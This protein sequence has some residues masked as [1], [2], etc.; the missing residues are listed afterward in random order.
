VRL[1]EV[2][3]RTLENKPDLRYQKASELKTELESITGIFE[4]LP[5]NVQQAF[6]YEYRSKAHLFGLPLVH[7]AMGVDLRTGKK[8]V[9]KGVIAIGDIAK[10]IF[11]FG[12]LAMGVVS[13]GGLSLGLISIGGLALGGLSLGGCAVAC[14]LAYG[15]LAIGPIAFGG[16]A[17][18][19]YAIGGSAWGHYAASGRRGSPEAVRFFHGMRDS[20]R[21]LSVG[22][23]AVMALGSL[24]SFLIPWLMKRSSARKAAR[25]TATRS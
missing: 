16:L 21:M 7:I 8:K 10:G 20:W 15:G 22:M 17:V 5:F 2:V 23:L 3:L 19:Y 12:G 13:F 25:P 11:A 4:K 9:A 6:G 18:G 24:I 1:D 14:V